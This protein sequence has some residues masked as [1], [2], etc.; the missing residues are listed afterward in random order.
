MNDLENRC[1]KFA[2]SVRMELR[3]LSKT[4]ANTEDIKQVVRSS[5]AVGSNY[6]EANESL[7]EKDKVCGLH[8]KKPKKQLTGYQF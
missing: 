2:V 6:I 8:A 7:G 1:L 5:G 4:I 3:I